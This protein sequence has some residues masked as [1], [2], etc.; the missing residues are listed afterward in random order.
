MP[1]EDMASIE[2]L[3][4]FYHSR[5]VESVSW[6]EAN[7]LILMFQW[8]GTNKTFVL[9]SVTGSPPTLCLSFDELFS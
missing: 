2:L 8:A 9:P 5:E 4:R 6:G 7:S 3:T 1:V